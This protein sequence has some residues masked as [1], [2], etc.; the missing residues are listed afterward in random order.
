MKRLLALIL[1]F[2]LMVCSTGVAFGEPVD[3]E[4]MSFDELTTLK[5]SIEQEMRTRNV[6]KMDFHSLTTDELQEVMVQALLEMCS[7]EEWVNELSAYNETMYKRLFGRGVSLIF[8]DTKENYYTLWLHQEDVE[9]NYMT[10]TELVF[11]N[12]KDLKI[13]GD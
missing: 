13:G 11:E 4:S 10:S 6:K 3:L 7:R 8:R 2:E 1:T 5:E 9:L 12:L